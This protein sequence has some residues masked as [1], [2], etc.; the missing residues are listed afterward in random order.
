MTLS[1]I[2]PLGKEAKNGVIECN[3][4]DVIKFR[5]DLINR[6]G[7]ARREGHDSIIAW[8]V[9][10]SNTARAGAAVADLNNG[11]YQVS[12]RCLWSGVTSKVCFTSCLML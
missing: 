2:T 4:G 11:S 12:F 1:K 5:V 9:G 7:Q 6:Y 10:D 8:M 3:V